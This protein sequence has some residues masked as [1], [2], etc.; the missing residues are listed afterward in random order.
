MSIDSERIIVGIN[1][2]VSAVQFEQDV[3]GARAVPPPS[4]ILCHIFADKGTLQ[5][6]TLKNNEVALHYR[7]ELLMKR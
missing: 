4:K 7:T 3:A 5:E 1:V 2:C 6:K